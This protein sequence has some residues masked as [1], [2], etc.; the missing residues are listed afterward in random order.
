MTVAIDVKELKKAQRNIAELNRGF[1][2]KIIKRTAE[3]KKS[4]EEL[5]AFSYSVS[6]DLRAP[7]RAIIGF[8]AILEEDYGNKLD[9]EAKRITTV[10][11]DNTLK[12]GHLIDDLL[13][14]S[15]MGRQDIIKTS[16]NTAEMVNEVLKELT[17]ENKKDNIEW[18]VKQLPEVKEAIITFRQEWSN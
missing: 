14:F 1:E 7:L 11:K 16:I 17:T 4:N 5:E 15:R 10:I 18:L 9:D 12:M 13:A 8:T 6:H 2:E 3:L